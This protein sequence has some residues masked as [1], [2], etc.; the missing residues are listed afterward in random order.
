MTSTPALRRALAIPLLLLFQALL[1]SAQDAPLPTKTIA[2]VRDGD[3][4]YFDALIAGFRAELETFADGKYT[5]EVRDTF[6]AGKIPAQVPVVLRHAL[7]T[8]DVHAVYAAGF[9]STTAASDLSEDERRVPVVGGAVEFVDFSSE[10]ITPGGSSRL[11]NY[12]FI[13]S[14]RRIATDLERFARLAQTRTIHAIVDAFSFEAVQARFGPKIAAMA[15]RLDVTLEIVAAVDDPVATA[16]S[17]PEDARA[18]YVPILATWTPKQRAELFDALTA[19]GMLTFSILGAIDV[20]AG[21]FAGLANGKEEALHRRIALNFHQILSGVSTDLLPVSLRA[22]DQLAINMETARRLD[23]S[24]D[25]DTSLAARFFG[26]FAA[27]SDGPELTLELAMRLASERNPEVLAEEARWRTAIASTRAVRSTWFPQFSITGQAGAQ[28]V[29]DRINPLTTFSH[30]QSAAFGVEIEQLLFSD[31]LRT[32][33][34]A[35]R[36]QNSATSLEAESARLDAILE[37][38]D[39]FLDA[40]NADK[41]YEIQKLDLQ[42]V[43]NNLRLAKLRFEIG[44]ADQSEIFRWS[45]SEASAK[46]ALFQQDRLRRTSRVRLNVALGA[47]RTMP[48]NLRDIEVGDRDL[49]FLNEELEPLITSHAHFEGFIDFL[50]MQA[51]DNSPE[52]EAFEIALKAQKILISER[53]RR[54]FVP[55]VSV[56]GSASHVVQDGHRARADAQNEWAVGVGFVLPLFE[57]GRRS[58]EAAALRSQAEQLSAQRDQALFFIEQ[59]A[60]T[61]AYAMGASHPTMR[62]NREARDA[63]ERNFATVQSQYQQGAA[64]VI[65]LLDAQSEL[66]RQRQN[67]ASAGYQYLKDVTSAQRAMAWFEFRKSEAEKRAW[68]RALKQHFARRG[69]STD[70]RPRPAVNTQ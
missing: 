38:A 48:R 10:L 57:G 8:P 41:L 29:E 21:A 58:A 17:V 33:L 11:K 7:T 59:R 56:T 67:E 19:R 27:P 18:I 66:L 43:E 28:G 65:T 15:T 52:V 44:S 69:L 51:A 42:I 46:A 30:V 4:P 68:I 61:A 3:S 70:A 26:E 60:L 22:D 25:Y 64:T 9:V 37:A 63:A 40:L 39:A 24:P 53:K 1:V 2:I 32:R 20:E 23:W 62:L 34:R 49:Y 36:L 14:P 50:R 31:Q 6:N 47:P 35:E 12:T 13:Q 45:A 55:V 54:N 16:A 5:V